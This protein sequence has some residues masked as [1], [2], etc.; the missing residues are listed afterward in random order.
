MQVGPIY[1]TFR[2][3]SYMLRN[4]YVKLFNRTIKIER[5]RSYEHKPHFILTFNAP[6]FNICAARHVLVWMLLRVEW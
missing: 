5:N 4:A 1:N 3:G 6:F 2:L